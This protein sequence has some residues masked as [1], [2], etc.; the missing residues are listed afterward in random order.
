MEGSS[1]RRL[2]ANARYPNVN[3]TGYFVKDVFL[4]KF[5]GTS[6]HQAKP[7]EFNSPGCASPAVPLG[8]DPAE[9]GDHLDQAGIEALVPAR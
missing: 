6:G 3:L 9:P 5:S 7:A 2:C 8:Q 1:G 4:S